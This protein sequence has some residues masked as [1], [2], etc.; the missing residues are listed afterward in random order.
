MNRLNFN[1]A[2]HYQVNCDSAYYFDEYLIYHRVENTRENTSAEAPLFH[3]FRGQFHV[4][5]HLFKKYL[6]KNSSM[7]KGPP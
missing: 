3:F 1:I 2:I 6:S 7:E 5:G 4:S